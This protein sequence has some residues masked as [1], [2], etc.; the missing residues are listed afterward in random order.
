MCVYVR[1]CVRLCVPHLQHEVEGGF[2]MLA[3]EPGVVVLD[4]HLL[5]QLLHF[6]GAPKNGAL[7]ALGL[8]RLRD[9]V[10]HHDPVAQPDHDPQDHADVIRVQ[11]P[12][13]DLRP[14]RRRQCNA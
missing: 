12:A 1:A 10:G 14:W 5:H 3:K 8:E 11:G 2:G 6:L 7:E 9:E 4:P 13:L